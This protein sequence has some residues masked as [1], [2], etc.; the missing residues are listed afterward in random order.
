[1]P[2]HEELARALGEPMPDLARG[3]TLEPTP[4]HGAKQSLQR[5]RS[6]GEVLLE[7]LR[8]LTHDTGMTT[9]QAILDAAGARQ[10]GARPAPAFG[11]RHQHRPLPT[12]R[13]PS[14]ALPPP[15][16]FSLVRRA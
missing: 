6:V 5:E 3:L 12:V 8:V 1:M 7:A 13:F 11:R 2:A 10:P 9:M 4:E 16:P 14:R 15:S